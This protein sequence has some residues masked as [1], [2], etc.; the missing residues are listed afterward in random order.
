MEVIRMVNNEAMNVARDTAN[1]L[2]CMQNSN[3]L[4]TLL[5]HSDRRAHGE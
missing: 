2:G 1:N 5:V 3:M 4:V